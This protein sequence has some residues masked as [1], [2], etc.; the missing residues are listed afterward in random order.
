MTVRNLGLYHKNVRSYYWQECPACLDVFMVAS[1]QLK[2]TKSCGC[3]Q[4][5]VHIKHGAYVGN[6]RSRLNVVWREMK[7][8]CSRPTHPKYP[9]YGGRGIVVCERWLDFAKFQEDM[10]E[11]P[12]GMSIDRIDNNKGYNPDNCRWASDTTQSQNKNN[13]IKI[14]VDNQTCSFTEWAELLGMVR[15]QLSSWYYRKGEEYVK[16]RIKAQ[17]QLVGSK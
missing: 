7:A 4:Y 17:I 12:E 14:T 3:V 8:R 15:H 1:S 11:A 10:G 2:Q 5:S 13:T 16:A 6:K 9:R